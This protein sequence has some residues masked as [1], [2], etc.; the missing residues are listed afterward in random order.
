M[1]ASPTARPPRSATWLAPYR[2]VLAD[3][4]LRTLL[5]GFAVSYLGDGMSAVAVSWLAIELAP[6]GQAGI[7]VALAVAAYTLPGAAGT[8]L[9]GRTMQG[10]SG[11]RLTAW[12]A[13]L[14]AAA[15]AA[16]PLAYAA[17]ALRP[18]LYVGLLA[19]SSLLHTWG[20]AGRYTLLA[21]VLPREHHLAGNA[22]LSTLAEAATLLGPVIAGVLT[23]SFGA[24]WVIGVDA[25]TFAVLAVSAYA[26][27]RRSPPP[28]DRPAPVA[29]LGSLRAIRGDPRLLG[30]LALTFAFFFLYGPVQVALPVHVA[31]DQH[32][33]AMLLA[34]YWTSFGVGAV[35]GGLATGHL[36]RWPLWPITIGIVV[37]WGVALMPVGLGA[38]AAISVAAFGLGGLIYAPYLSTSMALF[39]GALAPDRLPP[40]LA[41]RS[42]ILLLSSPVGAILGGP[43][44][45]AVGAQ[46]TILASSLTT[47]VLGALAAAVVSG[48]HRTRR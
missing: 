27:L 46:R 26:A 20:S 5:P 14:R 7:W 8:V 41:T 30:L 43:L 16:I 36:R 3:P 35:A 32:G 44:V 28:P 9:F 29:R 13:T 33:S 48:A 21:E 22:L 45:A 12:D 40:V 15:L 6:P 42:A 38:P 17:G 37:G 23:A 19:V 11:A 25:M 2:P 1:T 24:V 10:R 18:T 39:Q 4:V 34:A 31:D 47:V